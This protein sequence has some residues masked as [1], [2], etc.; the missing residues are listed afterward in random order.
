MANGSNMIP[1]RLIGFRVY[2]DSNDLLG[3]A[4]VTRVVPM[5]SMD[6]LI[7]CGAYE[8]YCT[9]YGVPDGYLETQ[10]VKLAE[11]TLP[12]ENGG[13]LNVMYG[14]MVISQMS[15]QKTQSGYWYDGTLP[16][17]DLMKDTVLFILDQDAYWQY[18]NGGTAEDGTAVAY[19]L[20]PRLLISF[21]RYG[22]GNAKKTSVP[23]KRYR[24]RRSG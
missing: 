10:N 22:G 16:D 2:N 24:G 14:N 23:G 6:V 9:L 13:M 21:C 18:Q 20:Y 8:G 17:I 5:L 3:I 11:G 1:E 15:N 19:A 4:N 12:S 7:K